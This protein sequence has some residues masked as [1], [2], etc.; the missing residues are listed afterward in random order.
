MGTLWRN[1]IRL[2]QE[3]VG[4]RNVAGLNW[5]ELGEGEDLGY[6]TV[7]GTT[8]DP[9]ACHLRVLQMLRTVSWRRHCKKTLQRDRE[10]VR[11]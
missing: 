4:G 11:S 7:S 3:V 2:G 10:G 9:Q 8:I 1:Q 6:G 5:V